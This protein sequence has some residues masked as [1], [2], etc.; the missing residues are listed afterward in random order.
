M[1]WFALLSAALPGWRLVGAA[2]SEPWTAAQTVQPA[3]FAMELQQEKDPSPTVIYV[4]VKTLY[5]G[6]HIPGAVFYGPGSTE[7]GISD[8]KKY[9]A[10]L[11]KNSDVVLYC[12]C[13]PLEKCPNLRPAFSALQN[14]GFARLRVLILP[15]SFNDDWVSQGYPIHKGETP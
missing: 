2:V 9:A 4:G 14:M 6:G 12:G 15:N 13:C 11:P 1:G 10:T 7:Q 8:L 5:A 3:Q